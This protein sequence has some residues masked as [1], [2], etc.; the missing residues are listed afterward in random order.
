MLNY[1]TINRKE[2]INE[3]IYDVKGKINQEA[4]VANKLINK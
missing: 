2:L 4:F 1:K 3:E